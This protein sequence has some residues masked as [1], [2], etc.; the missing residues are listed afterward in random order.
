MRA[1]NRASGCNPARRFLTA[2]GGSG[3]TRSC[4]PARRFLT[5][6]G[7]SGRTR[8][9]IPARR[10]LAAFGGSGRTRTCIPARRFLTAFGG[11]GRTRSCPF[12]GDFASEAWMTRPSDDP[13]FFQL[14]P[15]PGRSREST[16]VLDADGHFR[17][18]DERF[19]AGRMETAFHTWIRRHPDDG[20]W[21]LSNGYDWTYFTVVDVAY[22]VRAIDVAGDGSPVLVLSDGTREPFMPDF[23]RVKP[24]SDALY[25]F[26]KHA[27]VPG[28]PELAKFDRHA[29]NALA[30]WLEEADGALFFQ[31]G[32]R[33]W[34]ASPHEISQTEP[35]G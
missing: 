14:P 7:G 11:S 23:L 17:H 10:F 25:T 21:I 26:I 31:V 12:R 8:T 19:G 9:C 1:R 3:R 13:A 32:D 6:F 34:P 2:F 35:R 28:G 5:A 24:D 4:I 20:R 30:P 22:F 18:D 15:P 16:I 27:A 29:Q 33:R